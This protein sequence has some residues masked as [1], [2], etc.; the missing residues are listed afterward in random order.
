MGR[1]NEVRREIR[2]FEDSK[3]R[4]TMVKGIHRALYAQGEGHGLNRTC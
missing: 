4:R 2:I 3:G 1:K